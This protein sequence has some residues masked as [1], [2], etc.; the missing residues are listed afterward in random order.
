MFKRT[1]TLMLVGLLIFSLNLTSSV[2]AQSKSEPEATQLSK[3]KAKV[4]KFG[5]GKQAKI[6]VILRDQSKRS[7]YLGQINEESIVLTDAKTSV[8]TELPFAN[9]AD[10]RKTGMSKGAKI[11]LIGVGAAVLGVFIFF[12]TCGNSDFCG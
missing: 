7:G 2:S 12:K 1:L 11:A 6:E 5:T 9:I 8:N 10:V 3:L 4:A